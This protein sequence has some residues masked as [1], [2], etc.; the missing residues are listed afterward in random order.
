MFYDPSP[1]HST[2]IWLASIQDLTCLTFRRF[3]EFIEK[4]SR[5]VCGHGAHEDHL[6]LH[7]GSN[8]FFNLFKN[9]K[10]SEKVITQK[11]KPTE[12]EDPIQGPSSI[13]EKVHEQFI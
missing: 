10:K 12:V 13:K 8:I 1:R 2:V 5:K 11:R 4:I 3:I 9:I 7:D 6:P